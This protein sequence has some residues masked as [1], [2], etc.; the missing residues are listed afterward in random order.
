MSQQ[1][2]VKRKPGRPR[3]N[4]E[5]S[6][7]EAV[8]GEEAGEDEQSGSV[9]LSG[10]DVVG[11]ETYQRISLVELQTLQREAWEA[12][13]YD[14]PR[15]KTDSAGRIWA[16]DPDIKG[17]VKTVSLSV[18]RVNGDRVEQVITCPSIGYQSAKADSDACVELLNEALR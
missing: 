12:F 18:R 8:A 10:H 16:F 9:S 5:V 14:A 1:P 2:P 15:G 7:V 6:H 11:R 17:G 3:K 4:P 13:D